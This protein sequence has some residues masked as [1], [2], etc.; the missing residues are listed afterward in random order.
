MA[1]KTDFQ[2]VF[3]NDGDDETV[4]FKWRASDDYASSSIEKWWDKC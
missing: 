2:I 1:N 4:F 3:E